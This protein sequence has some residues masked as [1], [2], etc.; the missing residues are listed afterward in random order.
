MLPTGY[1]HWTIRLLADKA[2]ERQ[3]VEKAHFN[4]VGRALKPSQAASETIL[5]YSSQSEC[6]FR[7]CTK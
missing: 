7:C 4:T 6:G 1:A 5:G 3:I 2:V